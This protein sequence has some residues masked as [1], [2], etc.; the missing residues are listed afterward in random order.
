M[1]EEKVDELIELLDLPRSGQVIDIGCGKGEFLVRTA[2]RWGCSA[3]GVDLNPAFVADA[4]RRVE[5]AALDPAPEMIEGNGAEYPGKPES[6]DLAACL[7]ASWIFGG[8]RGSLQTLG[9]WAKP[10]G[11]VLVGEPFWLRDPS[12]E[13]I[14]TAGL[15][16]SSFGSHLSN[17]QTGLDQGLGLLHAVVSTPEDW[18][19]Y[20]GYQWAAAE[21]YARENPDDP[22]V[23][24]LIAKVRELQSHYLKWGREEIG[25]AIYLFMKGAHAIAT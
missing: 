18:D 10:G 5:H 9:A 16:S 22:D 11:L 19:R 7:G 8:F 20:H 24:E 3:I 25:W 15:I 23:P 13:H 4:R 12:A 14:E 2:R 17:V 6:F 21:R 1:G